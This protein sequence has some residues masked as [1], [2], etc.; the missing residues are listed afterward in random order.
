MNKIAIVAGATG[1]VG[2]E[3][4]NQLIANPAYQKII[5]LT[6]RPGLFASQVKV[7]ER[8]FP[9][10]DENLEG[11]EIYCALGTTIKKAGSREAFRAVDYD[12]VMDLAGRAKR[13]QVG[14]VVVVT[15]IGSDAKS[16]FFYPRV[17][18]EVERDL[19]A[20]KLKHL[21]IYRPSFLLGDRDEFRLGERIGE[22]F[23]RV[24]KPIFRGPLK[25]Y[26]PIHARD[27][28]VKMI[29]GEPI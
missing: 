11:D 20:L 29:A 7:V 16:P 24:F 25:K 12:L 23:C 14:R 2:R 9:A 19:M 3:I 6:R 17:K 1:L 26:G 5:V 4:V 15:A 8:A 10:G 22:V 27:L 28:A 21:E 13:G 18:G